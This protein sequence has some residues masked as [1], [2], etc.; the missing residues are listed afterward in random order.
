MIKRVIKDERC[1]NSKYNFK[2]YIHE[3]YQQQQK[4]IK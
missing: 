1:L 3:T 2:E 4:N